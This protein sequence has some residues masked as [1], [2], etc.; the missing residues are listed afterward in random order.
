MHA[1]RN[2][3]VEIARLLLDAGAGKDVRGYN[4]YTALMFAAENGKVE[5]AQLLLDACADKNL[6]ARAGVTAFS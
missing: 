5:I 6:Q 2:G 4:G 1:A 3:H